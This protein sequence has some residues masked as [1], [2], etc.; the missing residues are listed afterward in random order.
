[1]PPG[2]YCASVADWPDEARSGEQLFL[3]L[4]NAAREAGLSCTT[5]AA[6]VA[7][8]PVIM[9]PELRCA[10]RLHSRDMAERG[11]FDHVN[12]DEVRPE[13]RIRSA[14]YDDFGTAGE[15]IARG[16]APADGADP[17]QAL[18]E[19]STGG[20]ECKNLVDASFDSVGIGN[21]GDLWTLDFA[22][23]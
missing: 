7:V 11:F 4:L 9:K 12:P 2:E 21:F 16:D 17:F 13:D 22:G 19:L 10:A 23:P 15:S 5:G 6:S 8:R 18:A 1:M 14:G 3:G 20:S